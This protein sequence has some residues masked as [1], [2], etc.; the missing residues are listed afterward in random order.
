MCEYDVN[1]YIIFS[2]VND[3]IADFEVKILHV[4]R[5]RYF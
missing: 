2:E 3:L 1:I 4:S 5:T